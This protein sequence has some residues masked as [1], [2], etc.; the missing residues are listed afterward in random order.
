[1]DFRRILNICD[2]KTFPLF[3]FW[4][5]YANLVARRLHGAY[6]SI[7]FVCRRNVVFY[8]RHPDHG[9]LALVEKPPGQESWETHRAG[10]K[11]LSLSLPLNLSC[12]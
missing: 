4:R 1:M 11:V 9:F 12:G 3:L 5:W 7:F 6:Q 2:I 8:P 10:G